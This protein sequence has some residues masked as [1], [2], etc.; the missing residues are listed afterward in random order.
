MSTPKHHAVSVVG[1][2]RAPTRR[3]FVGR[4]L[5]GGGVAVLVA[6]GLVGGSLLSTDTWAAYTDQARLSSD[7][8]GY[9]STGLMD[10]DGVFQPGDDGKNSLAYSGSESFVPGNTAV[11]P[12]HVANNSPTVGATMSVALK[13]G[14]VTPE[15]EG[16]IRVSVDQTIDGV[17]TTMLGTPEDPSKS[18]A[19]LAD[20]TSAHS[21]ALAPRGTDPLAGGDTWSGPQDSRATLRVYLYLLDDEALTKLSSASMDL[22]VTVTGSSTND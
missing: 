18:T 11:L 7:Y 5:L 9:F 6:A 17:T 16:Q 3:R 1:R 22:A 20:L 8:S 15:V 12:L 2:H 13:P 10:S 19:T 21:A 4:G 14:A